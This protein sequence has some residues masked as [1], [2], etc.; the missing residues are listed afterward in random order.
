MIPSENPHSPGESHPASSQPG[1]LKELG[2]AEVYEVRRQIGRGGMGRVYEGWHRALG[3]RVALKIIDP[4]LAA[5]E[6][7]RARFEKEAM[8]LARLQEPVPHPHIVR[9]LDFK[10]L[11]DVGCIVMAFVP[12]QDIRTWCDQHSLPV[13]DR[14]ALMTVVARAA[15]YIHG[16]G[17]VHRDL[18]PANILV[19][20]ETG[21]PV[22]VD[23]GIVRGR[24][25]IT[26]TRTQQAL[27]TAAYMAPEQL[28]PGRAEPG[29]RADV[30]A[31]GVLLYELLTGRLPHGRTL[32]EVL[33]R[34]EAETAPVPPARLSG[35]VPR[36]LE[37][38][39]LKAISHRPEERYSTGVDLAEDLDRYLRAEPVLAR[40]PPTV[41][42]T[43]RQWRK[44]PLVIASLGAAL[45]L[46]AMVLWQQQQHSG[47]RELARLRQRIGDNLP[48]SQWSFE[49]LESTSNE[50][51][52]LARSNPDV[53]DDLL[54]Q[55]VQGAS[56]E[57][58]AVLNQPRLPDSSI[59]EV[60]A[61]LRW[62]NLHDPQ[63]ATR[64]TQ[65]LEGRRQRWET[66]LSLQAPFENVTDVFSSGG[67]RVEGD[68]L[69]LEPLTGESHKLDWKRP[70]PLEISLVLA[71]DGKPQAEAGIKALLFKDW[72]T[73]AYQQP[74]SASVRKHLQK[75]APGAP[76][77]KAVLSIADGNGVLEVLAVKPPPAG[78]PLRL[79][80]RIERQN[81]LLQLGDGPVV[82]HRLRY[83][84]SKAVRLGLV[85]PASLRLHELSLAAPQQAQQPSPLEQGDDLAGRGE[86][87]AAET[88]YQALTGHPTAG[89]EA[90]FRT[91]ECQMEQKREAEARQS[92]EAAAAG[93]ESLWKVKACFELWKLHTIVGDLGE[94]RKYLD[95]LPRP[96]AMPPDYL[97]QLSSSFIRR[98]ADPYRGTARGIRV[99]T[100]IPELED[101]IRVH[102]L[103]GFS[104]LDLGNRF[105]LGRH[106]N[107]TDNAA[108]ELFYDALVEIP[109]ISKLDDKEMRRIC[110]TFELWSRM[111]R[112]ETDSR[113]ASIHEN[114][115]SKLADGH[116]IIWT[117]K[118]E[119]ARSLARQG[120]R[121]E[122]LA[123]AA[124][125][126]EAPDIIGLT[127]SSAALLRAALG[128]IFPGD[129]V[130][131]PILHAIAQL[132]S[133]PPETSATAICD[134][135]VLHSAAQNWTRE[136]VA[137]LLGTVFS[138]STLGPEQANVQSQ[139]NRFFLEDP[140]YLAAMN[141]MLAGQEGKAFLR[142]YALHTRPARDLIRDL[143]RLILSTHLKT[144]LFAARPSE[145]EAAAVDRAVHH[146]LDSFAQGRLDEEDFL[147]LM[148]FWNQPHPVVTS[149]SVPAELAEAIE[150]VLS[151]RPVASARQ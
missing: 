95:Q 135:M 120:K 77:P 20:E 99:I 61:T 50:I 42:L 39:C 94:A 141:S 68:V 11:E 147:R 53:A 92:W 85:G 97:R 106:F 91:G 114:W 90:A 86:W 7:I 64:L 128:E 1:W 31:L 88:A 123:L 58:L 18:K 89:Q 115:R 29:P 80:A 40:P 46:T 21:Q 45:G 10:L 148:M 116:A 103:L 4:H 150:H 87:R 110:M 131:D 6:Q 125:V 23:F 3:I 107:G 15:G 96:E 17:L 142:D 140:A 105:A 16:C 8:T 5:D 36:E 30:Y 133:R 137:N 22:I 2:W 81:L 149:L 113:F 73:L 83:P 62:M 52:V 84:A 126:Q 121:E 25:D 101:A 129:P 78:E 66:L 119:E 57:V 132:G 48:L 72:Y 130:R 54:R 93:P 24:E 144:S 117:L 145:T 28:R 56:R 63:E 71:G 74:V 76:E 139:L 33:P 104:A 41:V 14:V 82:Q 12:G 65:S 9:V 55:L 122:A 100:P 102:Q 27:G 26:L 49:R 146:W 75:T 59:R 67:S 143:V 79:R 109:T 98:L 32:T 111:S 51:K 124:Q 13:A 43:L 19:R 151:L 44:R 134:Q 69:I 118:A 34:H 112:L 37:R 60:E 138:L 38:V 35:E 108:T 136:N 47:E 70:A 127:V